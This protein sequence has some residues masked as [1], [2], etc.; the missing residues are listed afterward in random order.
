M[1]DAFG[2]SATLYTRPLV[3]GSLLS[4]AEKTSQLFQFENRPPP[5]SMISWCKEFGGPTGCRPS[6]S[7]IDEIAGSDIESQG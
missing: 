7:C 5:I 3:R 1:R 6:V 4:L 2:A